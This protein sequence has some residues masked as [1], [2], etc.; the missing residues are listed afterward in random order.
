MSA[1][2]L[3]KNYEEISE[4]PKR[5]SVWIPLLAVG[6]A[7]ALG[8][9]I[10]LLNRSSHLN[11][12]IADMRAS[13][14][15]QIDKLGNA[16]SSLLDQRIR[17]ID[18]QLNGVEDHA[19]AAV[20]KARAEAQ[21]QG[22]DLRKSLEEQH[23]QMTAQ[24]TQLQEATTTATGKITE[25]SADV[26]SV[27]TD[28]TGVKTDVDGVKA[29][30]ASTQSELEKT[31]A[32]LKRV[33]GDMGVMS[34]LIA[35]NSKDLERLRALGERNYFEFVL[36]KNEPSKK[37]ADITLTLKKADFKRNRYTV[38]VL[39]DD[40]LVEKRDKTINEPVQVYVAGDRQP[41][42]IVINQVKKDEISGYLATPK[43]RIA[44]K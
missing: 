40:K 43:M 11:D 14:Q 28:V 9:D 6:L 25:V 3:N 2:D 34:G 37:V 27:K 32:E 41:Y 17:E 16:T 22:Q 36:A 35:T 15:D 18:A 23:S 12:V 13:T 30:V 21:K 38:N 39:A 44:R 29:N 7:A 4:A 8:G 20:K 24:L 33:V 1:N 10:Y 42:E 5:R 31:G 19:A 26:N